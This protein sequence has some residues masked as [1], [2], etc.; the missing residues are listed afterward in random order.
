MSIEP[1]RRADK[2]EYRFWKAVARRR[3][4]RLLVVAVLACC[5]HGCGAAQYPR[6]VAP[7]FSKGERGIKGM[8]G[9]HRGWELSNGCFKS[10]GGVGNCLSFPFGDPLWQDYELSFRIKR[11]KVGAGDQHFDIFVRQ[12]PGNEL[13]FYCRGDSLYYLELLDGKEQRHELIGKLPAPMKI[14]QDAP[15]TSFRVAVTGNRAE[16]YVDNAKLGTLD[17]LVL[18]NGSASFLAYNLDVWLDGLKAIV[19]KVATGSEKNREVR[20]NLLHNSGFELCTLDRLPDFWGCPH[21]GISDAYWATRYDEWTERF[22]T[23]A[24]EAFE[25]LRSMRIDNPFDRE[26]GS[27]LLLQSVVLGTKV[28]APYVFSAYL[29]S[30]PAGMK[31]N[32]IGREVTLS[33]HWTRYS[34]PFLNDGS[35]LYADMA[36]IYPLSKGTFW[37]D[38]AQLE[39]GSTASAYQPS[40]DSVPLMTQEGNV[41]KKITEVPKSEPQRITGG[42]K[43]DGRLNE[44]EWTTT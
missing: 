6:L 25:G 23:D 29:K 42:L 36:V 22:G 15:W 4:V 10:T 20:R 43:L 19:T 35:G 27:G 38:A 8:I 3:A 13:R 9:E 26:P 11:I 44:R 5:C 31:V 16:V 12:T 28:K 14:G 40:L 17:S 24:K 30:R 34:S 1:N 18:K 33:D 32:F 37:I 41:E 2:A 7:D 21:W 39:T